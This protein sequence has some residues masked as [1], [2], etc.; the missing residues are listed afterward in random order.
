[1]YL[2]DVLDRV[3]AQ[4]VSCAVGD[5]GLDAATG[6]EH[7]ETHHVMVAP[8]AL[9]HWSAAKLSA[10][11]H[12]GAVEKTASLEVLDEG[13]GGLVDEV[14][15]R[16]DALF[17]AVVMVPAPMVDLH[18]THTPLNEAAGQQAVAGEGPIEAL[19]AV[20]IERLLVLVLDLGQLGN[21]HLHLE[22][23][24]VLADSGGDA[25]IPKYPCPTSV[26]SPD[27]VDYIALGVGRNP[28]RI[29]NVEDRIAG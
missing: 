4:V 10:P 2:D 16:G 18:E 17:D 23:E 29:A 6:E 7:G 15:R 8:I 11:D 27:G 5:P 28:R 21:A 3:V 13:C 25:R 9:G 26:E 19:D 14:D 20:E 1:M 24:L 12:Q 22:G